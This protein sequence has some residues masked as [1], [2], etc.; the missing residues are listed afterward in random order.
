[1][2]HNGLFG[3]QIHMMKTEKCKKSNLLNFNTRSCRWKQK[4]LG[5][6]NINTKSTSHDAVAGQDQ[7]RD[8]VLL[9][10]WEKV[11]ARGTCHSVPFIENSLGVNN[12]S[13]G[14]ITLKGILNAS[15]FLQIHR[16]RNLHH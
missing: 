3:W 6:L 2:V 5:H 7:G 16:F 1:M 9:A 15:F 14:S 13:L 4:A 8:L 12:C 11:E 10:E